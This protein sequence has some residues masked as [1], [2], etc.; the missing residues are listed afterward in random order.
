ME[1]TK[2]QKALNVFAILQIIGG[3]LGIIIGILSFAFGGAIFENAAKLVEETAVTAEAADKIGSVFTGTGIASII[4]GVVHMIT[5]FL[6]RKAVK[7][8]SKYKPAFILV[9]I[10]FVLSIVG[11]ISAIITK[12]AQLIL[13]SVFALVLD[14]FVCY[15]LNKIKN[16]VTA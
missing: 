15:L 13:N 10:S 14:G 2:E 12:D 8:P 5:G 1:R 4:N 3:I 9:A 11:L 6:I 16:T 7:D